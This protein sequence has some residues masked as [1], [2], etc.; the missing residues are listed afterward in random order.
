MERDTPCGA[1]APDSHAQPEFWN[2]S[3]NL[4]LDDHEGVLGYI[5][6]AGVNPAE[7]H[8]PKAAASET[9]ADM[10]RRAHQRD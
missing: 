8:P 7:L 4:G 5:R 6:H 3:A 10:R 1:S 9:A 2:A